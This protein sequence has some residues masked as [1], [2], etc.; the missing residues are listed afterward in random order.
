MNINIKPIFAEQDAN[1]KIYLVPKP[2]VNP[3]CAVTNSALCIECF[4]HTY[5]LCVYVCVS[6]PVCLFKTKLL[7]HVYSE[8]L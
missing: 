6:A 4:W 5:K 1:A 7:S 3:E 8:R 2:T